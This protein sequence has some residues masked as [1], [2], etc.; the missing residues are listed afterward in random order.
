[1]DALFLSPVDI[2]YRQ[3]CIRKIILYLV[4]LDCLKFDK[5]INDGNF[6]SEVMNFC[7]E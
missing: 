5:F 3:I 6:N 1:M 7:L 4:K 2:G